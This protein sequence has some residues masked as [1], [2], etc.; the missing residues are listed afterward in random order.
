MYR[1]NDILKKPVVTFDTGK[2]VET[3]HDLVFDQT[4]NTVLGFLV[5]EGGWFNEARILPLAHVK[6]VGPDAVIIENANAIQTA[7]ADERF[8]R[9]IH[10][11]NVLKGTK[12]MTEDGRDLGTIKD[13]HFDEKTGEVIGYEVSGGLFGDLM[14]G[15]PIIPAPKAITIGEDVAFVPNDTVEI[16]EQQQ[17]GLKAA[18]ATASE[19]LSEAKD[20]VQNKYQESKP[21][22]DAQ[23]ADLK[24]KGQKLSEEA[25][26]KAQETGDVIVD[27]FNNLK[28][29]AKAFWQDVKER[30]VDLKDK[31]DAELEE[32]R[33]KGALGRPVNRVIFDQDDKVILNVGELITHEAVERSRQAG[34]LDVLLTSVYKR[35]PELATADMRA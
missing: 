26:V 21:G 6:T 29:Q 9:I 22:M 30:A 32:R 23:A 28:E 14:N 24:E 8:D 12:V 27:G 10:N 4:T 20:A 33:I 11:N 18:A 25:R 2:K 17:G 34:V 3:V 16:M 5:D 7:D 19:K 35:E 31:G 13:L 15:R 1:G